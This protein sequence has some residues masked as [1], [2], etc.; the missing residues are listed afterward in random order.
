MPLRVAVIGTR[1][2][3]RHHAR[4]LSTLP[5]VE[6]V[7]IVD[8]NGAR[9]QEVAAGRAPVV[10]GDDGRRALAPAD[11]ISARITEDHGAALAMAGGYP[12]L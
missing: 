9:A 7:A 6:L 3:G 5:D 2:H 12:T 1:H 11:Q 4:I 8:S 10:A